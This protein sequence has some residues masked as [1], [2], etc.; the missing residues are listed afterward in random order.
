MEIVGVNGLKVAN[1]ML[2]YVVQHCLITMY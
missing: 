1:L 2:S